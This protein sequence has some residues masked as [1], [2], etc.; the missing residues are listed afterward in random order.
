MHNLD[1]KVIYKDWTELWIVRGELVASQQYY[2]LPFSAL[3]ARARNHYY[4]CSKCGE[5]WGKR[6][7]PDAPRCRHFYQ[8]SE[9]KPCGGKEDMLFDFEKRDFSILSR[10]CIAYLILQTDPG[11]HDDERENAISTL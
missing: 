3:S 6:I 4:Y 1:F 11:G 8:Q 7:I 10:N 2:L 5:V 9:C